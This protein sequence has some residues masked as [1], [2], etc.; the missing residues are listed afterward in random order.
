MARKASL[1]TY[2]LVFTI[3]TLYMAKE[4]NSAVPSGLTK[5]LKM[6]EKV[7]RTDL[8]ELLIKHLNERKKKQQE[9][10]VMKFK[11]S[12]KS[13]KDNLEK[14]YRKGSKTNDLKLY[15]SS[16]IKRNV[17]VLKQCLPK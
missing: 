16:S 12:M 9:Y 4:A 1:I 15:A 7:E 2:V 10:C 6:V 5:L 17:A 3:I 14:M 11:A 8:H 13:V